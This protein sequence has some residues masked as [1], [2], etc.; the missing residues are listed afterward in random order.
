MTA[1]RSQPAP[2]GFRP[3]TLVEAVLQQLREDLIRGR[4]APGDR[5]RVDHVAA[6]LGISAFPVREALRVLL[7]EGRVQY[8]PHRGYRVSQLTF[9]QVEE[10][11]LMCGL[12][13]AEAVRRG[14]EALDEAGAERMRSLLRTLLAPPRRAS[15]WDLVTVHQEFHFVP[16]EYARLPLIEAEL[17]RL[18]DHT[19][20]S[21]SLY[22]FGDSEA[23]KRMD[24]AHAAIADACAARDAERAVALIAE[25]R[26][27]ALAHV[28]AQEQR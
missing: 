3:P 15:V 11:S 19:D 24:A 14:V 16:I 10:I 6:D 5:V 12:L 13:E 26:R 18:W 22:L 23:K 21:R 4:Y 27:Q 7:A 17:R 1:L 25:H 20:H 2:S 9:E 8:A 28:A